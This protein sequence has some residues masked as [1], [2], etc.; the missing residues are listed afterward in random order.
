MAA[1]VLYGPTGLPLNPQVP[2]IVDVSFSALRASLRPIEYSNPGFTGGHYRAMGLSSAVAFAANAS[3]ADFFF[4][5]ASNNLFAVIKRIRA[6]VYVATAVTAQRLD[7]LV[8]L[9]SRSYTAQAV[10]AATAVVLTGNNTKMRT[11]P[12]GSA[13]AKIGMANAAAG[14]SGGSRV[15]DATPFGGAPL[16]GF[17][18]I[19]GLGTGSGWQDLYKLDDHGDHPPTMAPSEGFTVNWGATALATGTIVAAVEVEWLEALQF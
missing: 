15:N 7:P 18:T 1:I 12:M 14:I 19:A 8:A 4:Q 6:Q 17:N 2:A 5:P 11:V 13:V 9:F 10:T 3:V 16:S